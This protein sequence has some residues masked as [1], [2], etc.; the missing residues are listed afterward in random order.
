MQAA[1]RIEARAVKSVPTTGH[2]AASAFT[3]KRA[4]Q[5]AD[6]QYHPQRRQR[7]HATGLEWGRVRCVYSERA[8]TVPSP[9]YR[10]CR[11]T[12]GNVHRQSFHF[13]TE[14]T[15]PAYTQV[16]IQHRSRAQFTLNATLTA[17]LHNVPPTPDYALIM[18]EAR[19]GRRP[20]AFLRPKGERAHQIGVP[21]I[22]LCET[23]T[24]RIVARGSQRLLQFNGKVP[25]RYNEAVVQCGESSD[26]CVKSASALDTATSCSPCKCTPSRVP[27]WT[28][29]GFGYVQVMFDTIV[30]NDA[31]CR[32]A[33]GFSSSRRFKLLQIGLGGGSFALA[34][35]RQCQAMVDV[36][37]GQPDVAIVAERYFGYSPGA[38]GGRLIIADGLEGVR[39]L[40]MHST[41]SARYDA[42]C[43]DCMVQGAIPDGCKSDEFVGRLATL[44]RPGGTLVQWSWPDDKELL[45]RRWTQHLANVTEHS[46]LNGGG[47]VLE[48]HGPV[49]GF[50]LGHD[51]VS[52]HI[53]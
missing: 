37:E 51:T 14:D 25:W 15:G 3:A 10:V 48:A 34:V 36:I 41:P 45:K 20:L 11:V 19:Y 24:V 50:R 2:R 29:Y 7:V 9:D 22:T 46:M 17:S 35:R 53:S 40:A 23:R 16:Q 31:R 12:R 43:I 38:H 49:P 28:P 30:G 32:T 18:L 39:T 27:L 8:V 44:L 13:D 1:A 6:A 42:I 47:F 52:R 26:I 21:F 4:I 5:A 33:V